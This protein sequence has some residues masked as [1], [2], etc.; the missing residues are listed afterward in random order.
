MKR[1]RTEDIDWGAPETSLPDAAHLYY[2]TL[3][4]SPHTFFTALKVERQR[5]IECIGV[6]G[7]TSLKKMGRRGAFA[8]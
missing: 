2:G 1:A 5:K 7:R 4:N 3:A 8:R 6:S